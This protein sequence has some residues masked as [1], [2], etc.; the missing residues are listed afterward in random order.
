MEKRK[1]SLIKCLENFFIKK[2]GL[3]QLQFA[4]LYGSRAIGFPR[5]DSDVDLGV[6]F[7]DEDMP[8][9]KI[10]EVINAISLS[11][12]QELRGEVNVIPVYHDFRKPMLYYN[13]IV[14]GTPVFIKDYSRYLA[15]RSEA[16]YQMEDFE[17]FGKNWQITVT[18]RN[19]EVLENAR[20]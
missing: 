2:A 4:F 5:H 17:I 14:K 16:V 11:L 8:E 10:Y 6:V 20:V 1:D 3:F 9:G 18:R 19:L 7:E 15:L 12:S 13:V